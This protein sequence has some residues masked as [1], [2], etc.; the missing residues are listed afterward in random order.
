MF[1]RQHDLGD[2]AAV[3]GEGLEELR[4]RANRLRVLDDDPDRPRAG[5]VRDLNPVPTVA[6]SHDR[7]QE[8]GSHWC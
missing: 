2:R 4:P 1:L 7:K 5:S 8:F 6:W 3:D